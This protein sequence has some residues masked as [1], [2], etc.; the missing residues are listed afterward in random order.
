MYSKD[1]YPNTDGDNGLAPTRWQAINSISEDKVYWRIYS[2]EPR[3]NTH[4]QYTCLM[5]IPACYVPYI[6]GLSV[7]WMDFR[8][9]IFKRIWIISGWGISLLYYPP[10]NIT[11]SYWG[12]VNIGGRNRLVASG[13][14]QLP[15]PM[16]GKLYVAVWRK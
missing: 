12:L 1:Q 8:Q 14:K 10:V 13:N 6:I 4:V 9:I 16:F 2:T 3:R 15:E 5:V 11:R 7:I